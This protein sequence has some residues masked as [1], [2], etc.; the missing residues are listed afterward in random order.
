MTGK[1]SDVDASL[2]FIT[3]FTNVV[4]LYQKGNHNCFGCGIPDHLVVDCPKDLAKTARK[5]NLNFKE[6]MAKK[7]GQTSQ[8]LAAA[9]QATLGKAP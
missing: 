9:Q 7:G 3:W 8:M 6:V 5:V 2:G 1:V 4:E